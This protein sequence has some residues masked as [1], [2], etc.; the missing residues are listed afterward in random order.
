M[1]ESNTPPEAIAPPPITFVF[2]NTPDGAIPTTDVAS[3]PKRKSST[4]TIAPDHFDS[5]EDARR[6]LSRPKGRGR[7]RKDVAAALQ[8]ARDMVQ[9]EHT[10]V[11]QPALPLVKPPTAVTAPKLE[12]DSSAAF[13]NTEMDF[14]RVRQHI[15]RRWKFVIGALKKNH[16]LV[17]A[18]NYRR[19]LAKLP[20]AKL[21][22]EMED[23]L[24]VDDGLPDWAVR[25][26]PWI[27]P[28]DSSEENFCEKAS[29]VCQGQPKVKDIL[30]R[31]LR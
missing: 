29:K 17:F 11:L 8:L 5:V 28:T 14:K 9:A 23:E 2:A 25:E 4:S 13:P 7:P 3:T 1:V 30:P 27:P 19:H 21:Y 31:D 6:F 22:K 16:P 10:R 26:M 12:S 15:V 24:I 18:G 20:S